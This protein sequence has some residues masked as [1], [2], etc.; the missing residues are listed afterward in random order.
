MKMGKTLKKQSGFSSMMPNNADGLF[1]IFP[2]D[3]ASPQMLSA[4]IGI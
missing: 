2:K 1:M 4:A 3:K